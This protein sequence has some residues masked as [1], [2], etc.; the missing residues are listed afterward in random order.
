MKIALLALLITFASVSVATNRELSAM[1][2]EDQAVRTGKADSSSD[3]ARRH[4]V[5]RLLAAG[6]VMSPKDKFNAALVLQHTELEIRDGRLTSVSPENYLLAHYL[7][8]QALDSGVE[9]ARPLVASSIDRY[10]SFTSGVQR[11]GTNRVIDQETGEELLI[12]IDRSV[13]DE[14]RKKYG[15]PPLSELLKM[16]REQKREPGAVDG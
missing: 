5:L 8:M 9:E 7:F 14:E 12:P 6:E 3:Q 13:L 11:Y 2:T 4:R 16:W 1:A 15:V 10:L